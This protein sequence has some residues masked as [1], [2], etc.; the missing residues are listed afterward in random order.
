[1]QC[2]WSNVYSRMDQYINSNEIVTFFHI[3]VSGPWTLSVRWPYVP[4]ISIL[5]YFSLGRLVHLMNHVSLLTNKKKNPKLQNNWIC[6]TVFTMYSDVT[7]LASTLT[8]PTDMV[9]W[10][11][12]STVSTTT[13]AASHSKLPVCALY[14]KKDLIGTAQVLSELTRISYYIHFWRLVNYTYIHCNLSLLFESVVLFCF[15][16][17]FL[18]NNYLSFEPIQTNKH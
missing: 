1:M 13:F 18:L 17:I 12:V 7:V 15:N 5:F 6:L 2:R 3:V 16:L 9:T 10:F 4:K 11:I 14:S 8:N